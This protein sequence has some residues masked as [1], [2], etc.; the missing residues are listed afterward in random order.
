MP[1][2]AEIP[3]EFEKALEAF[4]PHFGAPAFEHFKRCP[5]NRLEGCKSAIGSIRSFPRLW[6]SK[7]SVKSDS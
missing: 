6:T 2:V 1:I 7:G 4:R 3:E 5:E